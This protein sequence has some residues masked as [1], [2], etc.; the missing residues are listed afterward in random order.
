[1][2]G[3]KLVERQSDSVEKIVRYMMSR[4]LGFG[5]LQFR[6][7]IPEFNTVLFDTMLIQVHP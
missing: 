3:D 7:A 2:A 4:G 6:Y 5:P 1:M